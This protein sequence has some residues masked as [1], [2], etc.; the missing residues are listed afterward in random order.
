MKKYSYTPEGVCAKKI[1][2]ETNDGV[3]TN[4]EFIGGCNGNSKGVSSL[5]RG[6]QIADVISRLE[7]ITCGGRASSCPAQLA[8]ALKQSL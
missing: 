7:G 3:V 8:I 1:N 5:A 4:V 6:M 2:V